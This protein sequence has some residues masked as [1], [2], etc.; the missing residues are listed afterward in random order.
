MTPVTTTESRPVSANNPWIPATTGLA[1]LIVGY[2]LA[3]GMNGFAA[4]I[5]NI[6]SNPDQPIAQVPAAPTNETPPDTDD[7]P[8]LGDEDATITLVEFTDYQCPFCSRHFEQTH[9][10]IVSEYVDT[11]K[12]KLVVRDFPLGFHPHAQKSAEATECADDQDKFWEMH[13]KL[14]ETQGTWS[15]VADASSSFKQYAK[16]LGLNSA[17]F[18]SCLDNGTHAQ[19]VKDDMAAG[20]ASGIDGTPGFWI[21]GPDGTGQKISGAY[22]FDTFKTAFDALL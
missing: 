20:S 1:G 11:G 15:G 19:E 8:M 16:D 6:P 21:I 13:D 22:P 3:S 7:D 5:A 18:D 4:P 2:M 14:F 12:V 17:T 9:K 10:Q